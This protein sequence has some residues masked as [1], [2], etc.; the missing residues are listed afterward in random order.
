MHKT[1]SEENTLARTAQGVQTKDREE[2]EQGERERHQRFLTE[3]RIENGVKLHRYPVC[4][5]RR[6]ELHTR[7]SRDCKEP[8]MHRARKPSRNSAVQAADTVR[9]A[10]HG[11]KGCNYSL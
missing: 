9:E 2:T 5:V 4:S 1:L 3:P 7:L 10:Q 6:K 11:C 8:N